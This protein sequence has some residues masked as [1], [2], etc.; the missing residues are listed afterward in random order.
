MHKKT[1]PKHKKNSKIKKHNSVKKILL[2]LFL[3]PVLIL[4]LIVVQQRQT[5]EQHAQTSAKAI[6]GCGDQGDPGNELGVG[7]YCTKGGS[8][9]SGLQASN[10]SVN[11]QDGPALCSKSCS[12][13]AD[14][15]TGAT[16]VDSVVFGITVKG[17]SP[18]AC[19]AT[20]TTGVPSPQCLGGCIS[21]TIAITTAPTG[22]AAAVTTQPTIEATSSAQPTIT[23]SPGKGNNGSGNIFQLFLGFL[24][25]IL[26]FLLKLLTGK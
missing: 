15:G 24:L 13:T 17:C 7:K 9:C 5:Y 3:I 11:F 10:C 21:P 20:P 8:E 18:N 4:T 23:T 26:Q 16:C 14:C 2:L 25:M 22:T 1:L 6:T 12:T 19:I